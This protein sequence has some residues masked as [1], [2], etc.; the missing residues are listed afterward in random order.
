ALK[1]VVK[2]DV[3]WPTEEEWQDIVRK[4]N[5]TLPQSLEGCVSVVDGSEFK[6]QR[7]SKEPYQRSHFSVKKKQHS[8]NVLYIFLL[9]EIIIY[10]SP[11][12]I[13]SSDQ[14]LWNK[15]ELRKK[16][17]NKPYGIMGDG[18]FVFNR[19]MDAIQICCA[20]PKK[21]PKKS[22]ENQNPMLSAEEKERNK[23]LSS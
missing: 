23:V 14:A 5:P 21:K 1:E 20:T 4:F 11:A 10:R 9:H 8:L 15:L 18:G 3:T 19:K 2:Y 6:I 12:D 16:Y 17:E 13:G 22:K 7:P